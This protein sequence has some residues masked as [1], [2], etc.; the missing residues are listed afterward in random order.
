MSYI[1]VIHGYSC[2]KCQ[3]KLHNILSFCLFVFGRRSHLL[4]LNYEK[5]SRA[6]G[7][8]LHNLPKTFQTSTLQALSHHHGRH[9][10]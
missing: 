5:Q 3:N 6:M 8:A 4:S 9:A 2:T 10:R 1:T 7:A